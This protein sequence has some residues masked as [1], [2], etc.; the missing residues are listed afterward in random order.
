MISASFIFDILRMLA[1]ADRP[2]G[3]SEISRRLN[4]PL[5]TIYRGI[6]TLE[7]A[8]Y[9]ERHQSSNLFTLGRVGWPLV[10]RFLSRFALRDVALPFLRQLTTL[11][12]ETTALFVRIGWYHVRVAH[13]Y[14]TNEIIQTRPLGEVRDLD[15]GAAGQII[16]ANL[17]QELRARYFS[18]FK[19]EMPATERECLARLLDEIRAAGLA[20]EASPTGADRL[21]PA[22]AIVSPEGQMFGSISIE[23]GALGSVPKPA[24]IDT[25]RASIAELSSLCS[26]A[27]EQFRNPYDQLSPSG[28]LLP[29]VSLR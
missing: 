13:I 10:Q 12:G 25:L 26:A 16:L 8:G 22:F 20:T 23:G 1:T 2:L 14:G 21:S 15:D 27:P 4:M 9:A 28:I 3:P 6:A 29:S 7:E 17:Q 24:E 18:E 11:T 19:P 5:T